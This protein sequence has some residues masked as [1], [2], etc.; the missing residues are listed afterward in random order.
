MP[1][2]RANRLSRRRLLSTAAAATGVA[3]VGPILGGPATS[4]ARNTRAAA[5]TADAAP[6]AWDAVLRAGLD[7]GL[8]GVALR[9]ERGGEVL[10]NGAA[11][12]ATLEQQ[13]PLA[14]TDRFR[15]ASATKT[16]TATLVLQ[17]VDEGVLS[18]DDTVADWLDDPV[19]ARIP[20]VDR[21]TV[22]Q[23]LNHSSGVYDYFDDDSPF[24]QDAFFGPGADWARVWTPREL[25][26]YVDGAQHAPSFAPGEGSRYSNTGYVLL[27][28]I[29]EQATGR[30]YAELL[31]ARITKPLDLKDT[32]YAATEPVPGGTV[33]SYHLIEGEPVNA[34]A[35]HLSAMGAAAG[36]VSTTRDLARF[37]DALFGG[38][39]LTP[40]TLEEMLAFVPSDRPGIEGGLGVMRLQTPA[41]ELVGHGGDGPGST[42]RMFRL[43]AADLTV[44]L[45][46]NT[47]GDAAEPV[48]DALVVEAVRAALGPEAWNE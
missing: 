29:L 41:G 23:L 4:L 45:L 2:A 47:G 39:L 37:A 43:P 9:V 48:A 26:A 19:V 6:G 8:L 40:A 12:L 24:L 30:S 33:D 34:S 27:G 11:G 16:F 10:F 21:I 13:T 3:M 25:L 35:I 31:H 28:L 46:S 5:P 15:I 1:N 32:F 42:A 38:E 22:R 7:R 44:A 17:L 36:I 14:P 20:H 18:L